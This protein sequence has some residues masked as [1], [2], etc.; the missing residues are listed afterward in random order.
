MKG[1]LK[2]D[3]ASDNF[4]DLTEGFKKKAISDFAAEISKVRVE[5]QGWEDSEKKYLK[6]FEVQICQ[7]IDVARDQEIDKLQKLT[8]DA[9]KET[10]EELI[11]D[12][13]Y[14][15]NDDFWAEINQPVQQELIAIIQQLRE[16]LEVGFKAKPA[17]VQDFI[18]EFLGKMRSFSRDF[19]R[20]IF[21]DI[22]TNLAR[23]FKEEF[24]KDENGTTRNWVALEE[25][26]IKELCVKSRDSV[27]AVVN[28]FRYIEIDYAAINAGS[29]TKGGPG[30][31]ATPGVDPQ[32]QIEEAMGQPRARGVSRLNTIFFEK[33]L[34]ET[35]LS[36]V[37]DRFKQDV[38]DAL[39]EAIRKHVS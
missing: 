12:P 24:Q 6:D 32:S 35:E 21:K 8:F 1:A 22:N 5:G 28:R 17:E 3:I 33:L 29:N 16:V 19:V 7:A 34:S 14:K 25:P 13:I 15:L 39:E 18:D 20:R 4:F 36:K 38:D 23:R 37:K 2:K 26:K 11:N 30:S 9:T 27:L 10:M 31:P